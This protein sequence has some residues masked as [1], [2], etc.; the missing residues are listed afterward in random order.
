MRGWPKKL[1]KGLLPYGVVVL[2]QRFRIKRTLKQCPLCETESQFLPMHSGDGS[3]R[4]NAICAH[5]GSLERH[6]LLWLFLTR[7]ADVENTA[8]GRSMMHVAPEPSLRQKFADLFGERYLTTDLHDESVD[9]KMDITAIERPDESVDFIV[10]NHVLEHI[11]DDRKAMK[12]L[13]R[14]QKSGGWSILLAPVANIES[15]YEDPSITSEEGRLAAF[16]QVD[17]VRR[18]GADYVERLRGAGYKVR[19]YK[20]EDLA[21]RR[22]AK[23]MSLRET[24][25]RG[26]SVQ[27]EIYFCTK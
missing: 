21:T 4:A 18:Y 7:E 27:S 5:C 16:G 12:E 11:D 24:A 17:H 19:V 14:V 20:V 22:E 15:T 25:D 9:E 2:Y 23:K 6:R 8:N 1:V 3:S 10:A 26:D 13:C